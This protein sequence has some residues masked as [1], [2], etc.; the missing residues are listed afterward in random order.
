MQPPEGTYKSS[1]HSLFPKII[2]IQNQHHHGRGGRKVHDVS[3]KIKNVSP[4]SILGG[5][6][7]MQVHLSF[8]P[9]TPKALRHSQTLILE[10][11]Q[12][13][14]KKLQSAFLECTHSLAAFAFVSL[15]LLYHLLSSESL[16]LLVAALIQLQLQLQ[17]LELELELHQ[18]T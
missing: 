10:T 18:I 14:F 11:P 3:K 8:F 2:C 16:L 7:L 1:N 12:I 9:L 15:V 4:S 6:S 5:F 13:T 17:L